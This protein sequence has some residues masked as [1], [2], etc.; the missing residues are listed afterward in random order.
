M[1]F[2]S[3]GTTTD[4]AAPVQVVGS[5]TAPLIFAAVAAGEGHT[6]GL[7]IDHTVYCWGYGSDGELGNGTRN[8][9]L[10]PIRI[11]Q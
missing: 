6:C 3:D 7:T 9:H 8:N 2:R 5:G 11:I 1:L 4:R 10:T